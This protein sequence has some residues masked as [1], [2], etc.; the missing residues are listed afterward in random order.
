MYGDAKRLKKRGWLVTLI[1][2]FVSWPLSLI[3]WLVFR[4]DEPPLDP[5]EKPT[6]CIQCHSVIPGGVSR[7]ANCG[8]TYEVNVG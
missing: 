6:E 4:P 2:A 3:A 7:C 1:V 8:W 5:V